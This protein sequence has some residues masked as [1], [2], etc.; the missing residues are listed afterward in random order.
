MK[1]VFSIIIFLTLFSSCNYNLPLIR[2][3]ANVN[4]HFVNNG[5]VSKDH[6]CCRYIRISRYGILGYADK[7][8]YRDSASTTIDSICFVRISAAVFDGR[9][10]TRIKSMRFDSTGNAKVVE[11]IRMRTHGRAPLTVKTI[12][13]L[14]VPIRRIRIVTRSWKKDSQ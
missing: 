6:H 1:S 5:P 11:K 12:T 4:N 14:Y 9:I 2:F 7:V 3:R 10:T 8:V 13:K